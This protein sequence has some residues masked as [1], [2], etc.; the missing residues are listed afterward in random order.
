[1]SE[2][3]LHQD[4]CLIFLRTLPAGS[5]DAVIT[6]P[7]YSSGGFTR[8]DRNAPPITKYIQT[9]TDREW[10]NFYGDNRDGRSWLYWCALWISECHRVMRPGGYFLSFTDWRQLPRATDALQIGGFV[11]RGLIAWDKGRAARAPHKG[12]FRHQCEYIVWGTRGA[13][14]K[15][16]F[17][18]P[19]DGCIHEPILQRDKHHMTGKPTRL[20]QHLIQ[21]VQP[22]GT[23]LDPFMGSGTT[24]VA[25]VM[26]GRSFIG[27]EMH[28]G[29][30]DIAQRRIEA[31]QSATNRG[32]E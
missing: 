10:P 20:M 16:N 18:G 7:P 27:C 19:W 28:S 13:T 23:I 1:M 5:V 26:E 29:Y 11:W 15:A 3:S 17:R 14:E 30:F 22:G 8:G 25:A 32:T 4:D 12:Y 24:G 31:A 6:D 21:C 9:G 2:V